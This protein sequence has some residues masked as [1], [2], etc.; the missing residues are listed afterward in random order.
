MAPPLLL[1]KKLKFRWCNSGSDR[2]G[3]R[4]NVKFNVQLAIGR[5]PCGDRS[6]T[7]YKY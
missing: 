1:E 4:L 3:Y 5:A 7:L 6:N 2:D